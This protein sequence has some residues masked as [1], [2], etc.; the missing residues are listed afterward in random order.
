MIPGEFHYHQ[1]SSVDDAI[2]LLNR[3][4]DAKI[5]AGGHSLL[6]MMKL[7]MAEP[8]HLIDLN[9]LPEL[10]QIELDGDS[11]TIG[12]M[13]TENELIRSGL[14]QAR[15]PLLVEA[16]GLIADPQVRSRATIG[17]DI[18][19]GDPGN[20]HPALM[21]AMDA[22]FIINGPNGERRAPANGFFLGTYWTGL[23]ASELLTAIRIP[24]F[25]PGTGYGFNKIKR[26]TGDYATAGAS[27]VLRM[28][29]GR[30]RHIR[31]A[32]TNVGPTALRAEQAEQLLL[33]QSPDQALLQ[34]AAE[35]AMA[36]CEPVADLS[37][38]VQY[39]TAMA[40]EMTRRS[41]TDALDRA[42]GGR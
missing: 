5:V 24:A 17:G 27:V 26:K 4:E 41:L 11:I 40:G 30:I 28:E 9:G 2:S 33:G 21:L 15:C 39:K 13:C 18:A 20:D 8:A 22:E 6:P 14:L 19:H 32:L 1:A 42:G 34:K 7:R 23:E 38:D 16:A 31:I 35:A 29:A 25:A 36:V 12:A 10:K 37:G 3:F